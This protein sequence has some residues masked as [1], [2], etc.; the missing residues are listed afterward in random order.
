MPLPVDANATPNYTAAEHAAH[1]DALANRYN[2]AV[3]DDPPVSAHAKDDEFPGSSLDAKWTAGSNAITT[4]VANGL[5]TFKP[6]VGSKFG[7]LIR[8]VAPTGAF[9][10]I[11]KLSPLIPVKL[12]DCRI[13]LFVA[14]TANTKALVSGIDISGAGNAALIELN[15]YSEAA[16]WAAYNG[17]YSGPIA[18]A[19]T[20]GWVWHRLRWDT[21]NLY[22]DIS[23]NGVTW[24]QFGTLA[25]LQPDRVGL[26]I[27]SN[28]GNQNVNEGMVV[29]WFRVTE[30]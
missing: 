4:T 11:A 12:S 2:T 9:T 28:A 1:H 27:Y 10:V 14:R 20:G 19:V 7:Y 15:A 29:D 23:M 6:N 17:T 22:C 26:A 25:W 18:G 13:G 30:P 16:D 24:Y 5:L 3:I 21:T 8:Q